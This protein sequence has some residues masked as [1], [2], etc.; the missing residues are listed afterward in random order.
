MA[1]IVGSNQQN[2][3]IRQQS[4]TLTVPPQSIQERDETSTIKQSDAPAKIEILIV[5][6]NI[7]NLSTL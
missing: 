5:D 4:E 1:N 2:S 7:F 3:D 6:D